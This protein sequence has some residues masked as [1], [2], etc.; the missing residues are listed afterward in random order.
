MAHRR[1]LRYR[2][3][4][5]VFQCVASDAGGV[6][7]SD[8]GSLCSPFESPGFQSCSTDSDCQDAS[9]TMGG[10][11][12]RTRYCFEG[13]CALIPCGSLAMSNPND[14]GCLS[15]VASGR[16]CDSEVTITGPQAAA[17]PPGIFNRRTCA[18]GLVCRGLESDGGLGTCKGAED[19]G[20]PC[21]EGA[22]EP[23]CAWGLACS[24]G[25]CEVPPIEGPCL[26]GPAPCEPGVAYCDLDSLTCRPVL[27][28]YSICSGDEMCLP[29][30]QCSSGTCQART[31]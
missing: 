16:A 29:S 4:E 2:P 6:P 13:L 21:L 5:S 12:Y 28:L 23:G 7:A 24:C 18:P 3:C 19:V 11:T 14:G 1:S 27:G 10:V 31:P 30:L 25:V 26:D 8:G 9:G 17:A 22:S 20:G 15:F